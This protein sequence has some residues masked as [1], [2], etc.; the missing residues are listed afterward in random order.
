MLSI[1]IE[2]AIAQTA[3]DA[4]KTTRPA[5]K[6]RFAPRVSV[7]APAPSITAAKDSV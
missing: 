3:E 4:V 1:R 5:T 6:V 7:I 2:V